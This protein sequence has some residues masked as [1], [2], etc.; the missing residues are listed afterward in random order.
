MNNLLDPDGGYYT[1]MFEILYRT[2]V[3]VRQLLELIKI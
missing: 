3:F 1:K 2:R